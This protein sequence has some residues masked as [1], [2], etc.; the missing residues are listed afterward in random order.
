MA[1]TSNQL[2]SE[3][4]HVAVS[5]PQ[6]SKKSR[7]SRTKILWTTI[8]IIIAAVF[9]GAMFRPKPAPAL[10]T[11]AVNRGDMV[12]TVV[13][14]GTVQARHLVS[15][16]A[17]ASGQIK[18]LKVALGD[19]V[20]AGQIIAEIDSTNQRNALRNAQ[21]ALS[22]I[23]AQRAAQHASLIQAEANFRRQ[24]MMLAEDATSRADFDAAR[25]AYAA[26]RAQ[27]DA[28]DA[29]IDQSRTGLDNAQANLG[30]TKIV[31]PIDGTVVAV[32][33]SEGQTVNAVQSSPTIV[34]IAALQV[35]TVEAQISEAD[36]IHVVPG[37]S[38]YFTIL[39]DPD[40][41][42]PGVV[43]SIEPAPESISDSDS[44]N[45]G[46]TQSSDAAVYY[47]GLFDVPNDDGV[48]RIG[49]TAQ[50]NIILSSEK[51][52]IIVPLAA[53]GE[54]NAHGDYTVRV[55]DIQGRPQQRKVRIG[56]NNQIDAQV[57]SGLRL[58]ERVVIGEAKQEAAASAFPPRPPETGA[59]R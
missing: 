45:A 16:G 20:T 8:A 57:I 30:Y 1:R 42:F 39:G 24:Q 43:R 31:A 29:Q 22:N 21:A 14:T 5:K 48:L 2:A 46:T 27:L 4:E 34:K 18:S 9:I 53:L 37:Q 25:A 35:V 58:G 28:I 6:S 12:R 41:R 40:R 36:V 3:N 38:A 7:F 54:R 50:V 15:V 11:A 47:N 17:Q 23:R 49:M 26:A 51:N 32:I 59:A 19:R 56:T 52:V 44:P 55:L 33:A 13:A 10:L